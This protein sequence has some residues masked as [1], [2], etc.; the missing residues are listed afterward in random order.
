MTKLALLRHAE[1]DWNRERRIQGRTDIPLSA[2]GRASLSGRTLPAQCSGMRAVTS[3][4]RR[5]METAALLGFEDARTEPRIIEMHWGD[6]EG[7]KLADLRAELGDEMRDNEQRG[8]DFSPP[9]GET[10]R[11]VL[12]RVA[13]W[14]SELAAHD[15]PTLAF[16]HRGVIRA[17]IVLAYGWDM[18]G[19]PPVKLDWSAFQLF[20]LDAKGLPRP[21]RI[22]LR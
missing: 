16:T 1:T 18:R 7:S 17:M 6:W 10:P 11:Q 12:G 20:Q 19:R 8:L 9:G 21:W 22:N 13:D 4:L 3:P 5:C 14:L 2:A 15:R